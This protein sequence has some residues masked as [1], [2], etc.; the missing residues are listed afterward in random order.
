M[1]EWVD[2]ELRCSQDNLYLLWEPESAG[3]RTIEMFKILIR[4]T[5]IDSPDP[6]SC[7]LSGRP[8]K[9]M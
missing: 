8:P 9:H 1:A 5:W 2:L 3:A 6:G 4:V 7:T